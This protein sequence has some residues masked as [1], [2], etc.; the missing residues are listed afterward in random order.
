MHRQDPDRKDIIQP[1]VWAL[2][3]LKL[4]PR[5]P[6]CLVLRDVGWRRSTLRAYRWLWLVDS[7]RSHV[8]VIAIIGLQRVT[9][10]QLHELRFGQMSVTALLFACNQLTYTFVRQ[11][12]GPVR[13]TSVDDDTGN[14]WAR[15]RSTI[16]WKDD[17]GLCR[18]RG[19]AN[20]LLVW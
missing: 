6:I 9:R 13:P 11:R 20:Y 1:L 19:F 17:S 4:E 5:K 7:L 10:V 14:F 8:D 3:R 18:R 2:A 15:D 16:D 12:C